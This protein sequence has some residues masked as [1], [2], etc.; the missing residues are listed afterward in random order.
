MHT[1]FYLTLFNDF[2]NLWPINNKVT[3]VQ[4]TNSLNNLSTTIPFTSFFCSK[5]WSF[6]QAIASLVV[7]PKQHRAFLMSCVWR[8]GVVGTSPPLSHLPCEGT[9][10]QLTHP[11]IHFLPLSF[12]N[13]LVTSSHSLFWSLFYYLPDN[14]IH[15]I[16]LWSTSQSYVENILIPQPHTSAFSTV[17]ICTFTGILSSISL[18]WISLST[19]LI[20]TSQGEKPRKNQLC[21]HL[22]WVFNAQNYKK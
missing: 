6:L 9:D 15:S 1:Y 5:T 11:P 10:I 7:L 19:S 17:M 3:F 21:W 13:F 20:D 12:T 2:Y 4:L 18:P 16:I 14:K 8:Q 22:I